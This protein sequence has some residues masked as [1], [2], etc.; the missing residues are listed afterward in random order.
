M[1]CP[2]HVFRNAM[3]KNQQKMMDDMAKAHNPID[4]D[5]NVIPT[6]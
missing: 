4:D 1:A 3:Q 5:G 2:I 6:A